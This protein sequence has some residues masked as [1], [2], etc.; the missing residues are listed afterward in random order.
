VNS[1]TILDSESRSAVWVWI[2]DSRRRPR[3]GSDKFFSQEKYRWKT[4]GSSWQ[5]ENL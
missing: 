4:S 5:E 2:H 3:G 1:F